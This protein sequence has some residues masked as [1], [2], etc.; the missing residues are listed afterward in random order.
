MWI[1]PRS[2]GLGL[3]HGLL[4][5]SQ[6]SLLLK[7]PRAHQCLVQEVFKVMV[8]SVGPPMA[9]VTFRPC[10]YRLHPPSRHFRENDQS[11][12]HILASL[13]IVGRCAE[14][15]FRPMLLHVLT[16]GMKLVHCDSVASRIAA[17]FIERDE[18]MIAIEG[19]VFSAFGHDGTGDL[20]EASHKVGLQITRDLEMGIHRFARDEQ[21]HDLARPLEQ[22]IDPPVAQ[23]P[24]DGVRAFAMRAQ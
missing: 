2:V 24:L 1:G 17:Y 19:R 6:R 13:R 18:P 11:S 9:N 10:R 21:P 8:R 16:P 5:V 15:R 22:Q 14:H 20:L 7:R 12:P 3:A 23:H 4:A